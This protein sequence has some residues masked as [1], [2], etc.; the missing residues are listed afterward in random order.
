MTLRGRGGVSTS[1][2]AGVINRGYAIIEVVERCW[3]GAG[4]PIG[5]VE[6]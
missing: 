1:L 5:G 3:D 4:R 6:T 2:L